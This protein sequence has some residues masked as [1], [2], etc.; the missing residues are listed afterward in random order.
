[1][2]A[3]R[4]LK[5][6]GAVALALPTSQLLIRVL[7]LP[8]TDDA[9]I[10][11]MVRLQLEKV[12]PCT[13]EDLSV[14]FE[15][16]A[17]EEQGVRVLGAA[18]PQE[19]LDLL[20]GALQQGGVNLTRIDAALLGWWRQLDALAHPAITNG[21]AVVL[22]EQGGEWDFILA[23][24]GEIVQTRGFGRLPEAADLGRELMLSLLNHEMEQGAVELD[25]VLLV[26]AAEPE[27]AWL[28]AVATALARDITPQ[29]V[30]RAELGA[31]GLGIAR[32]EGEAGRLDLVPE[33]WRR[34][35]HEEA[36]ARKL[37][38]AFVA[39]TLL[40]VLLA[41]TLYLLPRLAEQR[42]ATI[43]ARMAAGESN[44]RSVFE[45]RQRVRLIRSYMDRSQSPLEILRELCTIMPPGLEFNSIT[46]RR[47]ESLKVA[48]DADQSA[49]VYLLKDALDTIGYYQS[50]RLT[51]PT[52]DGARRR[53]R[54][55]IDARFKEGGE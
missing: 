37:R 49:R 1:M 4:Q 19:Q 54:F 34:Q 28:A 55:D 36:R 16:L 18:V 8:P 15:V 35:A 23:Q 33:V 3:Q 5:P 51:G 26:T 44:Y 43:K 14:G 29:W 24:Q 20:A 10:G 52:L 50:T 2:A 42:N 25:A 48:G 47:D 13:G 38:F 46:Y 6:E 41:A 27:A 45:V 32:R 22:L 53:Y 21:T 40:W 30:P 7:R 11:D 9:N 31:P 17:Q 39:A 12:A